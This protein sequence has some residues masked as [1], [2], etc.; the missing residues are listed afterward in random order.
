[1]LTFGVTAANQTATA[2]GNM[3]F[4]IINFLLLWLADHNRYS[5]DS[6]RRSKST[7]T[8]DVRRSSK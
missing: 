7:E 6:L 5:I 2:T 4:A 3:S 8:E 1:V